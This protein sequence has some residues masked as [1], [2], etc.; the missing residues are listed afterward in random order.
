MG[1]ANTALQTIKTYV[2]SDDV[3]FN[4]SAEVTTVSNTAYVK[5][6]EIELMS[7]I[8]ETSLF[9]Y[10]FDLKSDGIRQACAEIRRNGVKIGA[11]QTNVG[12]YV[13]KT[14]DIA[15]TNFIVGEKLQI[16]GYIFGVGDTCYVKDFKICGVGSEWKTN[17]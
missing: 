3:I 10:K 9:R 1:Y 5:L 15:S 4:N 6:K 7:D 17:V 8:G 16:Y 13:T 2:P 14:E 12:A 11:F